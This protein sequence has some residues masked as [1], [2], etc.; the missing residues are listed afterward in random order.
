VSPEDVTAKAAQDAL[1]LLIAYVRSNYAPMAP[2][3]QLLTAYEAQ[4]E[5]L[6]RLRVEVAA[7]RQ[8]LA[9]NNLEVEP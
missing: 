9:L 6:A 4:G 3:R 2:T 7:L 5:E 1:E 8:C